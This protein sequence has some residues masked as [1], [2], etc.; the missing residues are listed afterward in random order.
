MNKTPSDRNCVQ[1]QENEKTITQIGLENKNCGP[2]RLHNLDYYGYPSKS[3]Q[4]KDN[5]EILIIVIIEK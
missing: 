3:N 1:T 4:Q 5:I 2:A